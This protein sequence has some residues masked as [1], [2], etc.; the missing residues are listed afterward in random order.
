MRVSAVRINVWCKV[1]LG[2]LVFIPK[3]VRVLLPSITFSRS[4]SLEGSCINLEPKDI[5][6][7][8]GSASDFA[9]SVAD[10]YLG[11]M[12]ESLISLLGRSS[13]LN[14][15]RGTLKLGGKIGSSVVQG[16]TGVTGRATQL[17]DRVSLDD[18]Y[19]ERQRQAR[20]RNQIGN[21][22]QG[23][24][25]AIG[26]LGEGLG[27]VLDVVR[28]PVQG[29]REGGVGGFVEGVGKGVISSVVKPVSAV[30]R[31]VTHV[32]AGIAAQ[33]GSA[34]QGKRQEV[35]RVR[36]PPRLLAGPR[37]AVVEFSELEAHVASELP[38][39]RIE[40]VVPLCYGAGAL[41]ADW[42]PTLQAL[43]LAADAV[44]H[45]EVPEP[46]FVARAEGSSHAAELCADLAMLMSL[47][48]DA[49]LQHR[50]PPED[51]QQ[52]EAAFSAGGA[53]T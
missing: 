40:V 32:G 35:V 33:V 36:R 10:E 28:R 11:D 48:E 53:G 12:L 44:H 43:V 42:P 7:E 22:G 31:A 3:W 1:N 49:G 26:E 4:L 5:L 2:T 45:V 14:V 20:Q 47:K 41:H 15:P 18:A 52:L 39:I 21:L 16:V 25:E 24:T 37:G 29:A 34:T 30:G 17:M 23:V 50:P 8:R 51:E 6:S 13:L 27:G 38:D 9:M 19:V 46:E